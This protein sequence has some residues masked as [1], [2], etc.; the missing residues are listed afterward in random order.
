MIKDK[1]NK[2]RNKTYSYPRRDIFWY[3]E[4]DSPVTLLKS[5]PKLVLDLK[6]TLSAIPSI[7][8][9]A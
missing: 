8:I 4:G 2:N 6:P 3:A 9:L 7:V 1:Q 5:A